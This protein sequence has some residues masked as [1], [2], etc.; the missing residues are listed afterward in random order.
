M[1]RR[2]RQAKRRNSP[3]IEAEAWATLFATGRDFF[4]DLK[5]W[6]FRRELFAPGTAARAAAPEAW[7]RLGRIF[8][9]RGLGDGFLCETWALKQFGEPETCL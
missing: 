2:Q 8:L 6:G 5:E 7:K 1:P 3:E 4:D 9:D